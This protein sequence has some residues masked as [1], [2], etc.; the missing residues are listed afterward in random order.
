MKEVLGVGNLKGLLGVGNFK[1][2]LGVELS[3]GLALGYG[4]LRRASGHTTTCDLKHVRYIGGHGVV[5][6]WFYWRLLM[7]GYIV[8]GSRMMGASGKRL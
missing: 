1:L 8:G 7:K 5:H 3:L 6:G 4:N 2:A